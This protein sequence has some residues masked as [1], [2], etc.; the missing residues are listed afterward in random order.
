MR[1]STP[2]KPVELE[3][4]I[5]EIARGG[6]IVLFDENHPEDGGYLCASARRITPETVKSHA[7]SILL[8]LG[9]RTRAQAVARATSMLA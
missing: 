5:R 6:S 8:K 9:T 4:A 2:G 1:K 3:A 7:K